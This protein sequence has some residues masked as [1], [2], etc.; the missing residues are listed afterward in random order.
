MA[1]V[2]EVSV[3]IPRF[4][5]SNHA[6]GSSIEPA[7][8]RHGP[9]PRPKA[10]QWRTVVGWRK[11]VSSL[12]PHFPRRSRLSAR[13]VVMA[14][15]FVAF[16]APCL[17]VRAQA[18]AQL[19][20]TAQTPSTSNQTFDVASIRRNK[21]EEGRRAAVLQLNPNAAIPPGRAQ[22]RQG[23][24][25]YGRG[26]S[27]RELIRDAYGYRNRAAADVV[28]GPGW[29]DSERYDV[30]AKG[31]AQFPNS[32]TLGLPPEAEAALRALLAERMKLRVRVE[33]QRRRVYELVMARDDRGLGSGLTPSKGGCLSMYAR[34]AIT[35]SWCEARRP[36][37][38]PFRSAHAWWASQWR[39]SSP[40]T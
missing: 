13:L 9:S 10:S 37:T 28:G 31:S 33:S 7:R 20:A 21:D 29:I 15:G 30:Q 19:P 14:F 3:Y 38:I 24:G 2:G 12:D 39:W 4:A 35:P 1:F 18:P 40:R 27:V 5:V 6:A 23:G 11:I 26:M 8:V 22:T 17:H 25:F 16:C 34:E 32:T 36:Q